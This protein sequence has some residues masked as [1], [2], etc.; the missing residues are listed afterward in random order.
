MHS[1]RLVC[2][3][4]GIWLAGG[5]FMA[6]VATQNFRSVDRLLDQSN[7]TARL[8]IKTLDD[9]A[10]PG[11]AR[12]LLRYQVSEQNRFYFETWEISQIV[13]GTLLFFFVL[14]GTSEGKKMIAAVLVLLVLTLA[15]RFVLTPE[16]VSLGRALDF[17]PATAASGRT[18]FWTFHS[19]Y[20][21]VEL[22]KW[23]LT[24]LLVLR[25]FLGRRRSRTAVAGKKVDVVVEAKG[26]A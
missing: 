3:L 7:P 22:L 9:N 11:A 25:L 15:Q 17:V 5:I 2:F 20:S 23:T 12:L 16:I 8:D 19:I 26:T 10:G 24:F 1:I 4:L 13:L 18:R 6:W 21:A 14:F